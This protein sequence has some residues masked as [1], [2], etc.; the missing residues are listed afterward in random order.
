MNIGDAAE[1]TGLPAKTL[2]YYEDIGLIEPCRKKNGYRE[3][4]ESDIHKLRFLQRARSLGFTISDCRILLSLYEDHGRASADVKKIAKIHLD[5]IGQKIQELES[6]QNT[7]KHLVD[8][9]KGDHRPEC[10]IL[11]D[12]SGI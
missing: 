12:L 4:S 10:P 2:R 11:N 1:F 9:C 8:T 3:Y 5:Q 6:L 7:L